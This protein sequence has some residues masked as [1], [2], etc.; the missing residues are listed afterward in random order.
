MISRGKRQIQQ[1]HAVEGMYVGAA[2]RHSVSMW[3]KEL[4]PAGGIP[5]PGKKPQTALLQG[6]DSHHGLRPQAWLCSQKAVKRLERELVG[7]FITGALPQ[8]LCSS[9]GGE[10]GSVCCQWQSGG[11]RCFPEKP[12]QHQ[13]EQL[14]GLCLMLNW[15]AAWL[16][17]AP[18]ALCGDRGGR[19]PV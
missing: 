13:W 2:D 15:E 10:K 4:L 16:L 18:I 7:S 5:L 12:L 1:E 14:A 17:I 11:A 3:N 9:M 19:S 8:A 6:P